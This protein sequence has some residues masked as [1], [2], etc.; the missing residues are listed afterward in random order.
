VSEPQRTAPLSVA[1]GAITS[2]R[3]A[4]FPAIAIGF[5]GIGSGSGNRF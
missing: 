2:I 4:I 1:L 3:S 5:S